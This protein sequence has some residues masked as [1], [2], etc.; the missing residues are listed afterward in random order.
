MPFHL[1]CL[2]RLT[3]IAIGAT[4]KTKGDARLKGHAP[5]THLYAK[6]NAPY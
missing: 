1:T 6:P 4:Y 3:H 5:P 2:M